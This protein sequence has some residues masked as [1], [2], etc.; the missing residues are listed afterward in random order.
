MNKTGKQIREEF[1]EFFKQKNHKFVPSSSLLPADDPTLLFANAGMNQFKPIFLGTEKRD[2]STAVNSQ[3]CIRAGGKHNDLEDVGRDCYH[4]TFFEMLGNWSFGDYFK[5]EAID[6]SWELLTGVWGLD[7][8]RLHATYFEGSPAENLEPDLEARDMW[9]K[10]LPAE[11]VHPGNKK[12]NFWEMGETGP[13]GPCS[14]VHIDLTDDISG[15]HL[16]NAGTPEN[17]EIWNL[18]FIQFNRDKTGALSLLPDKHVDTGM[19]LER[20]SAVMQGKKSNYGTDLFRNIICD[21]EKLSGHEY[22][23]NSGLADRYD[24]ADENSL[25]DVAVRVIADHARSLTFAIADGILPGNEGRSSVLR[26]I[27]RRAAGFGRQ[28]LGIQ[29]NFVHTLVDTIVADF[30]DAYPE[31][32]TRKDYIKQVILDEEESFG[33]TLDRGLELFHQQAKVIANTPG[34]LMSGEV[35]FELH[36]TYGFPFSLTKLMAEKQ[37]LTVDET[38]HIELMEEHKEKSRGGGSKFKAEAIIGLPATDDSAK[39]CDAPT[40]A[41]V[42]GWVDDSKFIDQG[43]IAADQQ[44]ALVL[45]ATS[46]YGESGGQVGDSGKISCPATGAIF[47]VTDTKIAG[48]SVLHLGKVIAGSFA[49]GQTVTTD[50][51]STP[52]RMDTKRNHSATHLLNWALRKVLG[53]NVNQAGSVVDP[54][55]LRFDFTHSKALTPEQSAQVEALVNEKILAD[56]KILATLMPLDQAKQIPGVRAMFGEKYPD[57]VRVITMGADTI[58]QAN[59]SCAV[60]FCGGTH[61]QRTSQVGLFKIVGE[62]SVAKGVRRLIAVTGSAAVDWVANADAILKASASALRTK[63][64]EIPTRIEAMQAEIKKLKKRGQNSAASSDQTT[65][66]TP[67]GN[68]IIAKMPEI[69][70]GAMRNYCDQQRQKGAIA[71]FTAAASDEK[72]MLIAMVDDAV[73][74]SGKLKAG[75]WVKN[76]APVVGGGGGGKPTMAQAGGREP[77]KIDLAIKTAIDFAYNSFAE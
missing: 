52:G 32:V 55:R 67:I 44:V 28:H 76:V 18:V 19:G 46:F 16:V 72:V 64:A 11:R 53:E 54:H 69:D 45:S 43:E 29:G 7:P 6:W 20:V 59:E 30:G 34:K 66:K 13:C 62:E 57:P 15:G 31:L 3:K 50:A 42:L 70:A 5:Q 12:D 47:E 22:G 68:V 48:A 38:A 4:H 35:T 17:I 26:S 10:H 41:T 24:T 21:I 63:P 74:K 65:L 49:P 71:V 25:A 56:E 33:K 23:K 9:L 75:D 1:I 60:E 8:N 39:Y 2:Y 51:N 77:G 14:E 40:E 58:E 36:A 37:G 73:A 27:L 61:L